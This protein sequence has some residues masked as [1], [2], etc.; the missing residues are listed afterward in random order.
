MMNRTFFLISLLLIANS[1]NVYSQNS[2]ID[3]LKNLLDAHSENDTLRINL[4]NE[5]ARKTLTLD[6]EQARKYAAEADN[7]SKVIDYKPGESESLQLIGNYYLYMQEPSQALTYYQKALKISHEINDKN[8]TAYGNNSIGN[9]Y[10]SQGDYSKATEYY[11]KA[12]KFFEETGDKIGISGIYNN[13][14]NICYMQGD[15]PR[16]LEY[17]QKALK[18]F[19]ELGNKTGMSGSYNNMGVVYEEQNKPDKALAYYKKALE[20]REELNDRYGISDSYTNMGDIYESQGDYNKALEYF[21]KALK[22]NEEIDNWYGISVSYHNIGIICMQQGEYTKSVDYYKKSNEIALQIGS[23]N[24][25]ALNA[26]ETALVYSKLQ[27]YASAIQY[28]KEGY[29]LALELGEKENIK[30]ASEILSRCY[31]AT[32]NYQKAYQYHVEFKT[33]SDSLFNESNIEKITNLENQYKFEKE[34]EAIA[35]EQAQKDAIQA[36]A[37]KRQKVIR[38]AFII[39]FVLMLLFALFVIRSLANKRKANARLAE[40]KEEIQ[41]QAEELKI[42]NE[43]LIELDNFKQGLTGMIVHDLKNP[44]NAIINTSNSLTPENQLKHIK[45]TGKQM[46]HMVMNILDVQKYQEN[47]M[48]VDKTAES[49]V[50]MADEAVSGIRFLAEEKNIRIE[51][52]ISPQI[53]VKADK[54]IIERV[55]TNLFTNAVKHTPNNGK[56]MIKAEPAGS[57]HDFVK[58]SVTDNGEGIPK[59]KFELVFAKFGQVAAKKSGQIRSTGLGMTFSKIAVEAHDGQ[60]G[61]ESQ[62]GAGTTVWFTL[63]ISDT[64]VQLTENLKKKEDITGKHE[65][66]AADK[67]LLRPYALR[68]K[69]LMVYEFTSVSKILKEIQAYGNLAIEDWLECMNISVSSINEQFYSE[70]LNEILSEEL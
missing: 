62:S 5:L 33:Q 7:L 26:I 43:K 27:N 11:Q 19:E 40:Q 22:I 56:I 48:T 18:I 25:I 50:D 53:S 24:M 63:P 45:H 46:L 70:L 60:I 54:E 51:N 21:Q 17:F 6:L 10:L 47:R 36:E 29:N 57:A 12:L 14:G 69:E 65:L 28:G 2:K 68:L 31:A 59:D 52:S 20:I 38:N 23:Q 16:T 1:F 42:A 66:T 49:L 34:K 9:I 4:L 32:G 13:M 55:F 39:G 3:S 30:E 15:Y 58:I 8:G 67:K 64:Q 61:L 37:M 41:A 44:L 35:A